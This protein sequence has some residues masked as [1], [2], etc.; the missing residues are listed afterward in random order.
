MWV[1]IWPLLLWVALNVPSPARPGL[2]F[3]GTKA[4]HGYLGGGRA[5][6]STSLSLDIGLW[7]S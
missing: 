7:L 5:V 3:K 6:G 4:Q 2:E 1:Q